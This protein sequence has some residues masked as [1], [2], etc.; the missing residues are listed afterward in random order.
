MAANLFG[1]FSAGHAHGYGLVTYINAPKAWLKVVGVARRL[2][3]DSRN[4]GQAQL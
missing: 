3:P 1:H 4:T 2:W